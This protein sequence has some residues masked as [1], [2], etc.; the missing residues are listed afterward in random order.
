M[1][2]DQTFNRYAGM[3]AAQ[4]LEAARSARIELQPN[5]EAC[6]A[7]RMQDSKSDC[8]WASR[9]LATALI[10]SQCPDSVPSRN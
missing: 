10:Q 9:T 6:K 5:A 3:T 2:R 4:L 1:T 7:V 8:G